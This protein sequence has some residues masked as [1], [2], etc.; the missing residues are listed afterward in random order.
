LCLYIRNKFPSAIFL[1]NIF[2][3][4]PLQ[5]PKV[6]YKNIFLLIKNGRSRIFIL[7]IWQGADSLPNNRDGLRVTKLSQVFKFIEPERTA[8]KINA[9]FIVYRLKLPERRT[10]VPAFSLSMHAVLQLKFIAA[11]N[12]QMPIPVNFSFHI[13]LPPL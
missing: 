10:P 5:N 4:N 2:T 12:H 9:Y 3:N 1:P 7:S 6:E 11:P 13:N 8:A